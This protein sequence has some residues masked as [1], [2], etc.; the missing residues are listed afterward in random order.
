[1]DTGRGE[2]FGC[3]CNWSTTELKE[4]KGFWTMEKLWSEFYNLYN[5]PHGFLAD[6]SCFRRSQ[7]ICF[8]PLGM[9][10]MRDRHIFPP[11]PLLPPYCC[12]DAHPLPQTPLIL[13]QLYLC[14]T[15]SVGWSHPAGRKMP[16]CVWG[17][18]GTNPGSCSAPWLCQLLL[19]DGW[20]RA[21]PESSAQACHCYTG[22]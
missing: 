5:W 9:Q 18:R 8:S 17:S 22:I 1:M 11:H 20:I 14:L 7:E 6:L 3:F 12:D 2:E 10:S 19:P 16:G 4:A 13:D 15:E 21:F